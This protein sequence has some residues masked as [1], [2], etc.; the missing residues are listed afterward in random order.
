VGHVKIKINEEMLK[1]KKRWKISSIKWGL[2][3]RKRKK[4]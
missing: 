2:G 3:R 4:F 1:S